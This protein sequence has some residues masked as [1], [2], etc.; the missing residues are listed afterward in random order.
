[1]PDGQK[2][3]VWIKSPEGR[4]WEEGRLSVQEG[5]GEDEENE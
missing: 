4:A 3:E 5:S 1:M 2:Y